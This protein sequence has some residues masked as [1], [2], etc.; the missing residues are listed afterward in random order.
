MHVAGRL[1]RAAVAAGVAT[2]APVEPGRDSVGYWAPF[3]T[4]YARVSAWV[5]VLGPTVVDDVVAAW[6]GRTLAM[7][8]RLE[9]PGDP[10]AEAAYPVHPLA[11]WVDWLAADPLGEGLEPVVARATRRVE[12]ALAAGPRFQ[13]AHRD[14]SREN[15]LVTASGPVLIDFDHAGP[16][17][18]WWEVVHQAFALAWEGEQPHRERVRAVL[19][20]YAGAGGVP[21][22]ADP[23]AFTGLLA[24]T[25]GWLAYSFWLATGQRACPPARRAIAAAD[26]PRAARRLTT[27]LDAAGEWAGWL[28]PGTVVARG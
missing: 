26:V 19:D 16:E 13:L 10:S 3:G 11:D 25:L 23:V 12:A 17:E 2:P 15:V 27:I 21:G 14:V 22:P 9:L 18:P 28:T 4:G 5:D 8:R 20:G 7:I 1:E 24:A 6:A